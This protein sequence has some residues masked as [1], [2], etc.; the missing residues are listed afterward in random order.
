L[1]EVCRAL[2]H[3]YGPLPWL[4]PRSLDTTGELLAAAAA[5][6]GCFSL[7]TALDLRHTRLPISGD[8]LL[9][10]CK[11]T[12]SLRFLRLLT[13]GHSLT[14]AEVAAA[15]L[16][17]P[18]LAHLHAP[19]LSTLSHDPS[20]EHVAG[21]S[22]LRELTLPTNIATA[23]IIAA[24]QQCI[25]LSALSFEDQGQA[26]WPPTYDVSPCTTH[27]PA[28]LSLELDMG[29]GLHGETGAA[30]L[31]S[32]TR[33]TAL[34]L[35]LLE[36]DEQQPS[37]GELLQHV[38]ALTNLRSL[39]LVQQRKH[40]WAPAERGWLSRLTRLTCL[41]VAVP[42]LWH[43]YAG[44]GQCCS[45]DEVA[46]AVPL[47]PALVELHM[48]DNMGNKYNEL[49]A[50][51]CA[52]IASTSSSLRVL[53]LKGLCLPGD[54][55]GAMSQLTCLTTLRLHSWLPLYCSCE[56]LT[57]L[58]SLKELM[59]VNRR[60]SSVPPC[61]L[62]ARLTTVETLLLSSCA[63]DRAW[64]DRAVVDGRCMAPLCAAMPQLR[65]LKLRVRESSLA[66]TELAAVVR[67][68]NLEVLCLPCA[69]TYLKRVRP[70]SSLRRWYLGAMEAE[71]RLKA[72]ALLGRHVEAV[73]GTWHEEGGEW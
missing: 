23:G 31:R 49:S 71:G 8:E 46:A 5:N 13:E 36:L 67:L 37:A 38:G 20:A 63:E 43:H 53:D 42:L 65:R 57:A 44:A 68:T 26:S 70:P 3:L 4:T 61:H 34:K 35:G 58:T 66:Q 28:L 73:F 11:A 72:G 59:Y 27:L 60:G 48:T 7:L 25:R 30:Q 21:W 33:L 19:R 62:L 16:H 52:C 29:G 9:A 54:I 40:S 47:M 41:A 14:L 39:H 2:R 56:W 32:Q 6:G 64:C 50:A 24:L 22:A 45:F 17:L 18:S 51:S 15:V 10:L 55:T 69:A 1:R 12:P